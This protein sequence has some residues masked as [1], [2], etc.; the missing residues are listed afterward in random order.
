M[1]INI[2]K[3]IKLLSE[4]LFCNYRRYSVYIYIYMCVCVLPRVEEDTELKWGHLEFL[5]LTPT[6]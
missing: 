1:A 5:A 2:L 3:K 4:R 6:P